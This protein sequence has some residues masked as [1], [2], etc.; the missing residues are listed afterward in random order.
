MAVC[1]K[2]M[3]SLTALEMKVKED[4]N[5]VLTGGLSETIAPLVFAHSERDPI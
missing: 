2:L 4:F 5:V 3:D 1:C